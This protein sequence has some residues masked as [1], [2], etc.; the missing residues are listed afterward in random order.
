MSTSTCGSRAA[1]GNQAELRVTYKLAPRSTVGA[2]GKLLYIPSNGATE[3]RAWVVSAVS[4]SVKLSGDLDYV[5]FEN[6]VNAYR[7]SLLATASANWL[8]APGWTGMLSGSVGTTPFYQ[9]AFSVTARIAYLF[10]NY[11]GK[12]HR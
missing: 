11:D 12:A 1:N 5:Y 7:T 6:P 9:T 2:S 3:L 10:S 4:A 8:F